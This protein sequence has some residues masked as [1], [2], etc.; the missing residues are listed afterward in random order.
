MQGSNRVE[1]AVAVGCSRDI[2][3]RKWSWNQKLSLAGAR[4]LV[5]IATDT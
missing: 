4:K 2:S 5:S 1:V 3:A